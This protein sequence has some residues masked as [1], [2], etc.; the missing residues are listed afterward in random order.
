MRV[1]I[2]VPLN[3]TEDEEK[4]KNAI[5]NIFPDAVMR[6]EGEYIIAETNN[7]RTLKELLEKQRIRDTARDV[8]MTSI[9]GNHIVFK[10]NKQVATVGRVNFSV[11][12]GPLGDIEVD[13]EAEEGENVNEII[14]YIAPSTLPPGVEPRR[15]SD[16]E[17]LEL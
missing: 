4:V 10:I 17:L 2:R 3:P 9:V 8:L 1:K 16:D 14:N 6:T 12:E 13:I 11:T 7:L 15:L 5:L